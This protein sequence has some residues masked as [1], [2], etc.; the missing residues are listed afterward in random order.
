MVIFPNGT[1]GLW[2]TWHTVRYNLIS[3]QKDLLFWPFFALTLYRILTFDLCSLFHF[4]VFEKAAVFNGDLSTWDV[5]S[6]TTM[7][8]STLQSDLPSK[9]IYY[10]LTMWEISNFWFFLLSSFLRS[11][12]RSQQFQWWYNKVERG[13]SNYYE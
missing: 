9:K 12:Q 11:V 10:F 7:Q 6:V 2:S 13:K 4:L 1:L 8:Q 5:G 3:L